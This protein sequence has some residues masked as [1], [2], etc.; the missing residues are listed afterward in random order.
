MFSFLRIF[1]VFLISFISF[2]LIQSYFDGAYSSNLEISITII[3]FSLFSSLV[4]WRISRIRIKLIAKQTDSFGSVLD[5]LGE[6]VLL[7]S[8]SGD[9]TYA[10]ESMLKIFELKSVKNKNI[11]DLKV[12][13]IYKGPIIAPIQIGDKVAELIVKNKDEVIKTLPLYAAEE[14]NKVNFFKSL[15]T[16]INYLIWGDV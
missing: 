9:I 8:T 1:S 10:N 12:N 5:N 16:S 4:V 11:N 7:A 2:F 3:L 14:I 13:L 15:V 6:G